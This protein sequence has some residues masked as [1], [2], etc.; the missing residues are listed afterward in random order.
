[1]LS[2]FKVYRKW[3]R[4]KW[5]L[6]KPLNC[7]ATG[8]FCWWTRQPHLYNDATTIIDTEIYKGIKKEIKRERY[9]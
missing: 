7:P 1:M 6:L 8:M 9:E 3:K 2:D 4:G 5:Y